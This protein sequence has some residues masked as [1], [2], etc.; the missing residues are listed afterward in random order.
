[1]GS[2]WSHAIAPIITGSA[3]ALAVMYVFKQSFRHSPH[4]LARIIRN[5][6]G[7]LMQ[8]PNKMEAFRVLMLHSKKIHMQIQMLL[9][10]IAPN[11]NADLIIPIIALR[12]N[13][14]EILDD[15]DRTVKERSETPY[16]LFMCILVQCMYEGEAAEA[17]IRQFKESLL[18]F[19]HSWNTWTQHATDTNEN[20][21][22]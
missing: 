2:E 21:N 13:V 6:V 17:T 15:E 16:R 10:K 1:M 18:L 11:V 20:C 8:M 12:L 3:I 19:T 7:A 14:M 22:I 9:A 5:K 4:K